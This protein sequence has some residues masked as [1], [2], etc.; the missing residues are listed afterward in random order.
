MHDDT[1]KLVQLVCSETHAC[2]KVDW[3]PTST[4]V[5]NAPLAWY[6]QEA[7]QAHH[8]PEVLPV[9]QHLSVGLAVGLAETSHLRCK[10]YSTTFLLCLVVLMH[11]R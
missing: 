1:C 5:A 3:T 9:I 10:I 7:M 8:H 11:A 2:Y 6:V 4:F